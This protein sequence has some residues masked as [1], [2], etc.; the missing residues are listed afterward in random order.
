MIVKFVVLFS[1][2]SI[3]EAEEVRRLFSLFKN[4]KITND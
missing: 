4:K 1:M 3:F 2:L